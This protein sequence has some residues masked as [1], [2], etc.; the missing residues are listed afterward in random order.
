MDIRIT[1]KTSEKAARKSSEVLQKVWR[2]TAQN[3]FKDYSKKEK[4][5]EPRYKEMKDGSRHLHCDVCNLISV[6]HVYFV[7]P[8]P[9]NS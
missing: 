4:L 1:Q 7:T 5:L 6:E 2:S 8:F 3:H 9:S